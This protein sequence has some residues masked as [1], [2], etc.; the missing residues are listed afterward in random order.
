ML[1]SKPHQQG[2]RKPEC[3]RLGMWKK[4]EQIFV[5]AEAESGKRAPLLLWPFLSN[6]EN[7]TV[8]QFFVKYRTKSY[9]SIN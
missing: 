1:N 5:E 9:R 6:V 3:Y 7:L 8:L 4:N 2:R